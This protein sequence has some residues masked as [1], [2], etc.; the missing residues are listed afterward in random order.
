MLRARDAAWPPAEAV[1][2]FAD[3]IPGAI[4]R[5]LSGNAVLIYAMN[6][7]LVADTIEQFVTGTA[8]THI[9]SRVPATVLFTDIVGATGQA[10]QGGD[11]LWSAILDRHLSLSDAAVEAPPT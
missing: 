1:H 3:L 10:A 4:Y 9:V 6:P 2:D 11:R 7:D 8:P 5:E